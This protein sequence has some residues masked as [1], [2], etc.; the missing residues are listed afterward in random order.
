[1]GCG[2]VAHG[3]PS[4]NTGGPVSLKRS[5][6]YGDAVFLSILSN[7]FP[8]Q[9]EDEYRVRRL[10]GAAPCSQLPAGGCGGTWSRLVGSDRMAAASS[11]S[12]LGERTPHSQAGRRCH[13]RG[14]VVLG[15]T[16]N[17]TKHGCDVLE[18]FRTGCTQYAH[19]LT[20]TLTT[21]AQGRA[22]G[23]GRSRTAVP[24]RTAARQWHYCMCT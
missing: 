7:I 15:T 22:A 18:A 5:S 12:A 21:E 19:R 16:L 3:P 23:P 20:L 13:R 10:R 11:P 9:K 24:S 1:M 6:P 4:V 14:C 17:L 8:M 2:L